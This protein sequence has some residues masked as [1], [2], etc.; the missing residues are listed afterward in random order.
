MDGRIGEPR[1]TA[2]PPMLVRVAGGLATA[3]P[4]PT[5]RSPGIL[6]HL[7]N[8]QKPPP[9]T[10]APT[11]AVQAGGAARAGAENEPVT[12]PDRES[13]VA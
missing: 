11:G 9:T 3:H 2:P 12:G 10:P 4:T 8:Q 5:L 1:G 13:D 7:Y 6:L